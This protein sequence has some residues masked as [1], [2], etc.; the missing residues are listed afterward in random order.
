MTKER[1]RDYIK[2]YL[3]FAMPLIMVI[4]ALNLV[5]L[6]MIRLPFEYNIENYR[7]KLSDLFN[8]YAHLNSFIKAINADRLFIYSL[9]FLGL[10]LFVRLFSN[11][12]LESIDYPFRIIALVYIVYYGFVSINGKSYMWTFAFMGVNL[13]AIY[14]VFPFAF[15]MLK[16]FFA[17]F[18]KIKSIVY[19]SMTIL[20]LFALMVYLLKISNIFLV[21]KW[22]LLIAILSLATISVLYYCVVS[23]LSIFKKDITIIKPQDI[24]EWKKDMKLEAEATLESYKEQQ[25]RQN[26][27]NDIADAVRK[28]L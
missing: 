17:N 13:F 27:I 1:V 10:A 4:V 22:I 25:R 18:P 12:L 24:I 6:F 19:I 23:F 14:I 21:A 28:R 3:D 20:C 15:K 9:V 8:G 2:D 16:I 11:R 26:I 5:D 7:P